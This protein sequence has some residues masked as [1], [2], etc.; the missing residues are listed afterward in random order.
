MGENCSHGATLPNTASLKSNQLDDCLRD[1]RKRRKSGGE[2]L[3]T[4][5]LWFRTAVFSLEVLAS[6]NLSLATALH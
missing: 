2:I 5:V 1:K 6:A 4:K 3:Q